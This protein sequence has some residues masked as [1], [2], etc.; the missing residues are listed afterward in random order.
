MQGKQYS[1]DGKKTVNGV[2]YE[3]AD[4]ALAALSDYGCLHFKTHIILGVSEPRYS[5]EE[6][7]RLNEE[8]AK[9]ITIDGVTKSGCEWKQTMR[10]LETEARKT[11]DQI[12]I[13]KSSGDNVG[14]SQ[15]RK[16]LSAINE[17][18]KHVAEGS[19]IKAQPSRMSIVKSSASRNILPKVLQNSG[20]SGIL[21]NRNTVSSLH[22]KEERAL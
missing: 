6:L 7:K 19:G 4:K 21:N 5:P 3:S 8:N 16:R 1:I 9:P 15:M 14:V 22:R 17:K 11:K 20:E 13:L 12:E 2:T 10:R 18:Y